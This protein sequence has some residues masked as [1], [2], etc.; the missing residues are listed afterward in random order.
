MIPRYSRPEMTA[1]WEPQTRFRIWFE[2]EAHAAAAEERRHEVAEAVD[3]QE[4]RLLEQSHAL[5]E[6]Y[7]G[8]LEQTLKRGEEG[9]KQAAEMERV[10]NSRSA[11]SRRLLKMLISGKPRP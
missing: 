5:R 4:R 10:L 8:Y 6:A 1:I 7:I 11:L 3:R 9:F 2:I